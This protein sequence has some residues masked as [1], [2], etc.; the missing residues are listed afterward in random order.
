MTTNRTG[1]V[2]PYGE[3]GV[4]ASRGTLLAGGVIGDG[5]YRL[6]AQFGVD[7]RANAQLWRA[8]DGQ[9]GRDVA[10]TVL[11][12]DPSN[13]AGA[14]AARRVLE[15][16]MHAAQ[17]TDDGVARVLDVLS[18]GNGIVPAEGILGMV[19]ADWTSGTDL[20]D[21]IAD[22]PIPPGTAAA[23]LEPLASAVE[24]AHHSGLV[25]GV[26]H[27]Q[28]VRITAQGTLRLAF[29]APLPQATLRDDVR[30]LG[31]V[32]YLLL[33]GRWPLAGGPSSLPAAPRTP[34]D[35]VVAPRTLRPEIPLELSNLAVRCLSD[36]A[37]GGIRTSAAIIAVLDRVATSE[38]ETTVLSRVN[39]IEDEGGEI[40]EDNTIWTTKKP[41][42]DPRRRRKLMLSIAVLTVATVAVAVWLVTGVISFFSDSDEGAPAGPKIGPAPGAQQQ[43]PK[44]PQRGANAG[45]TAATG[46]P[47]QPATIEVFNLESEPDNPSDGTLAID[48]DPSTSW[49]TDIYR[50]QFPALKAGVGLLAA[51]P[52]MTRL[53]E[54]DIASPSPGTRVQIRSSTTQN[55]ASIEETQLVGQADLVD[56]LTKIGLR[57]GPPTQYLLVW[58]TK[59]GGSEDQNS[60]KLAEIKYLPPAT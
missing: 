56:G 25:L 8:R 49:S 9:L 37:V 14:A 29:P 39:P 51:F 32:L 34:D 4:R 33:T 19:V 6:L 31:A 16:A 1:H 24:Q 26:D 60:S 27:P 28:R 59:L 7:T 18:L 40:D 52:V 54:V 41:V 58:V 20:V 10:L 17:F 53:T 21:L 47:V 3:R 35:S 50:Q 11:V 30:G 15:R 48:H 57:P 55:P 43:A 23:L 12:G 13:S 46:R 36:T 45:N 44:A 22:G 38:P 5:R 42:N 2:D